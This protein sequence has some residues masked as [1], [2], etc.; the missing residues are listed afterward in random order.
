VQLVLTHLCG[1][2]DA[3]LNHPPTLDSTSELCSWLEVQL[4]TGSAPDSGVDPPGQTTRECSGAH[5]PLLWKR[6]ASVLVADSH[7]NSLGACPTAGL[8]PEYKTSFQYVLTAS[9]QLVETLTTGA[10]QVTLKHGEGPTGETKG[11]AVTSIELPLAPLLRPVVDGRRHTHLRARFSRFSGVLEH[12]GM[13]GSDLDVW[14][15]VCIIGRR[16]NDGVG[17]SRV[18]KRPRLRHVRPATTPTTHDRCLPTNVCS[19]GAGGKAPTRHRGS[20]RHRAHGG[21]TRMVRPSTVFIGG[22]PSPY[23]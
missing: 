7:T 1:G 3:K 19:A 23:C 22:H 5:L 17:R 10:I 8:H 4:H 21:S 11:N 6:I 13:V 12:S 2:A 20:R 18:A 14:V 16:L 9:P 15:R